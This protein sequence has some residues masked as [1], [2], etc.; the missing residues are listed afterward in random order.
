MVSGQCEK[1]GKVFKVDSLDL[2]HLEEDTT[3]LREYQIALD[4][5]DTLYAGTEK[6]SKKI[7]KLN[8]RFGYN[9]D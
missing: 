1:T 8:K 2:S 4:L 5:V 6:Y 7:D 3:K 9:N